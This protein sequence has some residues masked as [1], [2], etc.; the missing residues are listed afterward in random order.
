MSSKKKDSLYWVTEKRVI[1]DLIPYKSNPRI[2]TE[3]QGEDLK[4]SL[5]KFNLVEL[6]AINLDGTIIAGHQRL[7]ILQLLGR[8]EEEIE[9]RV[10]N[11]NLSDSE[12]K[13]YLVRSN[14]N[15]GEWDFEILAN[16]FE[17]SDL[18]NWGFEDSDFGFAEIIDPEE[19][20]GDD[21]TP[22]IQ[23]MCKTVLGDLYELGHHRL[24]CGDSTVLND[25]E[26]VLNGDKPQLMITDPPYGVD[27][28]PEWRNEVERDS[29][30]KFGARATG[31]VQND[32]KFDWT[33]AWVLSP[34]TICYVWH[35]AKFTGDVQKNLVESGFDIR[36]QII[37]SKSNFAISR[38]H[39]H[40]KHEA[41]WYGVKPNATANWIGDRSQTTVWEIDKPMKNE[42]GHGTQ[43]PIECMQKPIENHDG[44]VYEPFAGS[45]TT[46][47]ACQKL[48]RKCYA[49][50]IDP[51]YCDVIVRRYINFCIENKIPYFVK[52]N[53]E[54][55]SDFD[56]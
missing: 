14:K 31:K 9:V 46:L 12:F 19:T 47:I 10:P 18:R 29:G 38:G 44:D 5:E 40:W 35:W 39:Y 22:G 30:K 4:K 32:D 3:K 15:T 25:V 36:S 56:D 53:G 52:R 43:K 24:L 37:W 26:K 28:D 6:P 54:E 21:E 49:I 42:T 17:E 55:V 1:N 13:E 16:E 20:H 33:D 45:G 41:C 48:Q 7:K 8:G 34:S 11:R 50:E 23:T 27:Y 2:L 51:K